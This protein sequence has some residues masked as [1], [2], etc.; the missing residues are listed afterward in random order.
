M[1]LPINTDRLQLR[2]FE[3][4]DVA[5]IVEFSLQADFWL[6]RNLDW[7]PSEESV[8]AYFERQRNIYPESYPK[9]VDLIIELKAEKKAVGIVGIGV[10][11]K[12]QR[13]AMVGCALS[14]QYQGQGIATEAF[15]ALL[16]YGFTAMELHR[17]FARTGSINIPSWHL[18][19]RAGMRREAHFKQSHKVKDE[20]DDEFVYAILAD[21]FSIDTVVNKWDK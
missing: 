11:N 8:M 7:E 18:M 13:Q 14:C 4:I 9:W 20:W 16:N 15:K 1:G 17:I 12:E 10:T 21:E 19:E 5:D 2:K 3:D 6:A